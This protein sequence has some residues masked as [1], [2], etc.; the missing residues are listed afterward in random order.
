M[1]RFKVKRY[2]KYS[3]TR[4]RMAQDRQQFTKYTGHWISGTA[5]MRGVGGGGAHQ[6]APGDNSVIQ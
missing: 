5:V 1:F 3:R 4:V 6:R 2:K